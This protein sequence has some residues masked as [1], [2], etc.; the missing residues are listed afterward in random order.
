VAVA[1]ERVQ[2]MI[3]AILDASRL[4]QGLFELAPQPVDLATLVRETAETLGT[5]QTPLHIAAPADLIVERADP[6]RLRQALENLI[7][8]A[9][10]HTP[11]GVPVVVEVTQET[12]EDGDWAVVRV[13]DQGPGIAPTLFERFAR[14][15][16]SSGLGLGLYLARGIAAA[17]GGTLTVDSRLGA[18]TTFRLALPL[19]CASCGR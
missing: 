2:R 8:N 19:E 16:Q 5:P 11:A 17:H 1:L 14:G 12:H 13:R 7:G 10:G 9:L 15:A 4:E 6:E 3:G 18:G